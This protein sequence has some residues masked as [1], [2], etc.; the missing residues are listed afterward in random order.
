M[1]NHVNVDP[2]APKAEKTNKELSER[3]RVEEDGSITA[4]AE[5]AFKELSQRLEHRELIT[6]EEVRK[7]REFILKECNEGASEQIVAACPAVSRKLQGMS[8]Y[9]AFLI[10]DGQDS[11][12][13]RLIVML[14]EGVAACAERALSL[15]VAGREVELALASRLALTVS[16]LSEALDRHRSRRPSD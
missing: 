6:K 9:A 7:S 12:L 3:L 5:R 8:F 16:S 4:N 11:A 14:S 2:M 15:D 13:A 1:S 10:R